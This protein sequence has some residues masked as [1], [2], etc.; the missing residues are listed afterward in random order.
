MACVAA[1][2]TAMQHMWPQEGAA[3]WHMQLG[4][5]QQ[6][7]AY[8]YERGQLYGACNWEGHSDM[9][10]VAAGGTAMRHVQP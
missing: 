9:T 1:G 2:G 8:G 6:R 4:G 7:G 3:T 5:V 10:H